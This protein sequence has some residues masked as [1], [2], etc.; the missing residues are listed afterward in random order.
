VERFLVWVEDLNME[1]DAKKSSKFK[2]LAV[3]PNFLTVDNQKSVK[4]NLQFVLFVPLSCVK[5][6]RKTKKN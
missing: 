2:F 5:T 3:L 6:H 1:K 4:R